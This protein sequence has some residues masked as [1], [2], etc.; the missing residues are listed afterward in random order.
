MYL[1]FLQ[2]HSF[3]PPKG[4]TAERPSDCGGTS[5]SIRFN[6]D[7]SNLEYFS[8]KMFGWSQF[9]LVTPNLGGGTG[10]NTGFGVRGIFVGGYA[11]SQT[12]IIDFI[13]ISTLATFGLWCRS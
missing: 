4:T 13:T 9:E 12:D 11:P 2:L 3:V 8:G 10:S 7:T 5:G 6:T 1:H